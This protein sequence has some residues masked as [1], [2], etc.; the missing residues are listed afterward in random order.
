[1]I[2]K[3]VYFYVDLILSLIYVLVGSDRQ[4]EHFQARFNEPT[5]PD[6]A[7]PIPGSFGEL[8]LSDSST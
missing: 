5:Q 1:M 3:Y 4:D 2:Y 8:S 6:W 7:H